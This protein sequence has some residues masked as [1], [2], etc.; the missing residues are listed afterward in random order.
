MNIPYLL[1]VDR[2]L[3]GFRQLNPTY[4]LLFTVNCSLKYPL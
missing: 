2:Q 1:P 4:P 3:V